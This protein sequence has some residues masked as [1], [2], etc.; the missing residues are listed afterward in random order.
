MSKSVV[1]YG[2]KKCSTCVKAMKW[3]DAQGIQYRFVDY[4]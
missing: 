1:L 3:L 4:R 2:L